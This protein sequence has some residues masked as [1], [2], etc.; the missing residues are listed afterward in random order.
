[1]GLVHS[2]D[3]EREAPAKRHG[4]D[5]NNDGEKLNVRH[6][7]TALGSQRLAGPD[8]SR[9]SKPARR[10][11]PR[12]QGWRTEAMCNRAGSWRVPQTPEKSACCEM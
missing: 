3:S 2:P 12:R 1:M 9:R 7:V 6:R 5:R 11:Q 4:D 10:G 8:G